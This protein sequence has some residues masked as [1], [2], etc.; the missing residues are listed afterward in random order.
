MAFVR[1]TVGVAGA[2]WDGDECDDAADV[3]QGLCYE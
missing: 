1:P 3:V 2:F